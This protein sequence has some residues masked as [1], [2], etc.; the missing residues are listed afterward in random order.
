MMVSGLCWPWG[1]GTLGF[2]IGISSARGNCHEASWA[3]NPL[4]FRVSGPRCAFCTDLCPRS[5]P[6]AIPWWMSLDLA[7]GASMAKLTVSD[8]ARVAGVARSTL[9]RAIRAG[10]LSV[11]P[12]GH[13]DTAELLRAGYTLQR[14]VQQ[15]RP[16]ALQDAPPRSSD[17]LQSSI[18]PR[19]TGPERCAPGTRPVAPGA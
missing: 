11:D 6:P 9:H 1:A 19:T 12:D 18:P 8:A 5:S 17:A 10:R 2:D 7:E 13:I 14:S 3:A 4:A 15:S 16:G